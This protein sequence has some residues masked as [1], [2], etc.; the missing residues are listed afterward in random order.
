M[1]GSHDHGLPAELDPV[2]ERLRAHCA[3]LSPLDLDRIK[4]GSRARAVGKPRIHVK[5]EERIIMRTRASILAVLVSGILLSGTGAA[6]GISGLAG[7]D[8][9][10]TAQYGTTSTPTSTPATPTPQGTVTPGSQGA[11]LGQTKSNDNS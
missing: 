3:E 10:G 7:S 2:A 6:L 1:K 9:A 8:N 4:Q 5:R 11:V